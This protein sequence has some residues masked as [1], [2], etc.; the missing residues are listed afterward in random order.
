MWEEAV[1]LLRDAQKVSPG[2]RR[3]GADVVTYSA[4]MAACR[5]G[6]EWRQALSI[7][8]VRVRSVSEAQS[9]LSA[10]EGVSS[11]EFALF[12]CRPPCAIAP[13]QSLP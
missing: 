8:E 6:G 1:L 10:G 7:M 4:A 3:G 13:V 5:K 11:V 9:L 12:C 2:G